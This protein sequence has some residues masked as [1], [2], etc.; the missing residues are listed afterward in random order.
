MRKPTNTHRFAAT[1]ALFT[2]EEFKKGINKAEA[3]EFVTVEAESTSEAF[4]KAKG[5]AFGEG[6]DMLKVGS[7]TL[8][9]TGYHAA[10][11][12]NGVAVGDWRG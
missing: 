3:F 8:M 9:I 1:V 5:K 4:M 2:A 12:I 11:D 6:H 10:W 7:A